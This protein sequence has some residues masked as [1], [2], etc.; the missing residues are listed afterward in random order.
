M[1]FLALDARR[2]GLRTGLT[3]AIVSAVTF[4]LS[5]P[6]AAG[7]FATG[8]SPGAVVL[9]RVAIGAVVV[10]PFGVVALRGDWSPVRRNARLLLA[11]G[12]LGVA[13]T[14]FCYFAAVQHMQVGPA[15]LIATL[16][17]TVLYLGVSS[18]ATPAF[19]AIVIVVLC[20]LQSE[21]V[22]GWF[23]RRR[24]PRPAERLLQK[25]EVSA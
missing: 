18:S 22:R 21:R 20:L 2:A 4:S 25:E 3:L 7:L 14:Q 12:A 15:L 10:L 5:G 1:S 16:D 19:K 24:R 8:W 13:A 6:L 11:Y 17:K 9:V 23:R